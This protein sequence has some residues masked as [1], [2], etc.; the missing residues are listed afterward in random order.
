[1]QMGLEVKNLINSLLFVSDFL[2]LLFC[3]GITLSKIRQCGA[4]YERQVKEKIHRHDCLLSRP[5]W[6]ILAGLFR[7]AVMDRT[8]STGL[9][10]VLILMTQTW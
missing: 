4:L 6:A 8:D 7:P 9:V 1:M 3:F 5:R 2:L 10:I